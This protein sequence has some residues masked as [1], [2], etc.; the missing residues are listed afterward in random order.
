V[1]RLPRSTALARLLGTFGLLFCAAAS[2]ADPVWSDWERFAKRFVQDDGRVVD[3]TFDQKSTSEGQ[4]YGLFFALV[5]NDRARFDK[6][7]HWTSDNL[8][9]GELGKKLPAWLWG[10]RDD[11][12][13]GVKD[14]NSAADG[15]LWMAYALLEAS[16]A[17]NAPEYARIGRGL[18]AS[19]REKEVVTTKAADSMPPLTLLL[20][21][22]EGFKLEN[23]RYRVDPSY[24]PPMVLRYFAEV[25]PEGP[26]AAIQQTH[27]QL[28]P[29]VYAG[30]YAPDLFVVDAKGRISAD[31]DRPEGGYDAIRVYMWA[32]MAGRDGA[33]LLKLLRPY[34]TLTSQRGGP[35]EKINPKTGAVLAEFSPIGYSGAVLPFL[36]V[37]G[38]ET[39]MRHQLSRVQGHELMTRVGKSSAY[40]DESLILFGKG[41]LD[42]AFRFDEMGRLMTRWYGD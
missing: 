38:D 34:A 20:P 1:I 29:K 36:K 3:I 24:L 4:S 22:P 17:W 21:G 6:I 16:R 30:G 41:W 14:P 37:L 27:L 18:L 25:D 9:G 26:W 13:W 15:E 40:Y 31:P 32:A 12:T 8:A 19:M 23:D 39:G 2:A 7:L 10:E 42:Q 11:K 28:A 5:A 35:P 33:E